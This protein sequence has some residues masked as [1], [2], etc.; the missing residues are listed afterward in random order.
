MHIVCTNESADGTHLVVPVTTRKSEKQDHTCVLTSRNHEFIQHKSLVEYRSA[1]FLSTEEL[2]QQIIRRYKSATSH[3][4]GLVCD[5]ILE[6]RHT[7]PG[8]KK[9]YRRNKDNPQ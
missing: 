2:N 6:S 3:L 5:G 7:P 8:I 9:Y 1:E 4:I